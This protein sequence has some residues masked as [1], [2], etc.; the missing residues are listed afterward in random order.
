MTLAQIAA[1]LGLSE[2]TVSRAFAD[3]GKVAPR[4]REL[5]LAE[6]TALGY[7]HPSTSRPRA[8][9]TGIGV[10]VPDIANPFFPPII[11][12]IQARAGAAGIP[13]LIADTDE[14]PRDELARARF[15]HDKVDGLILI[16]PRADDDDLR[17]IALLGPAVVINRDVPFLPQITLEP[18]EGI[19][20]A[21]EHLWAL[22]HRHIAYLNG[23]SSSWSNDQRRA[24]V[25]KAMSRLGGELTEFG[26][27]EPTMTS[28]VHAADLVSASDATAVLAYDDM[29]A[30][31]L[32]ARMQFRGL[33]IGDDVSVVGIDDNPLSATAYPSLTTIKIPGDRAGRVAVD[34]LTAHITRPGEPISRVRLDVSLV[35]RESTGPAPQ[36]S[37]RTAQS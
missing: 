10:I 36:T 17:E 15:L 2:S 5:V 37:R 20:M 28:G 31:G 25:R 19:A 26:P 34:E 27:F 24:A 12:A 4:T 29:I 21:V 33:R 18:H 30:L 16:S 3:P 23:P 35:V 6:A 32:M 9:P 22:G 8:Q 7:E 13:V 1:R 14:H 11:R